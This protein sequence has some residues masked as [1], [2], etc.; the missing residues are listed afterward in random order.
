MQF[1]ALNPPEEAGELEDFGY[2]ENS[3][4]SLVNMTAEGFDAGFLAVAAIIALGF[5]SV[6]FLIVRNA[7]AARRAGMDPVTMQT[8]LA[9]RAMNSQLLAAPR[10]TEERLAELDGLLSRG[11]ISAEEHAAARARIIAGA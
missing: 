2:I 4:T 3:G 7:K 10:S 11:V 1:P 6:I 8:D 5:L 9:A